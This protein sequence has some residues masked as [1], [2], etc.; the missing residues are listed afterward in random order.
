MLFLFLQGIILGLAAAISFGPAFFAVIQ[1]GI[2]RGFHYGAFMSVGIILSDIT[3]VTLCY[4]LGASL[5]EDPTNKVYI[6]I[7][8]GIILIIFG[9]VSWAKKPE[10]L[11][12]RHFN[13]Q[14]PIKTPNPPS[15]IIRGFFLNIANPFLFLFWFAALSFVGKNAPEGKLLESTIAFFSGTFTIILAFDLLKSYLGGRIKKILRPRV[16]LWINK[17]VGVLMVIF[18]IVLIFNTLNSVHFFKAVL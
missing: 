1:T 14:T 18:G 17:L 12:K 2:T 7:V 6:G 4:F 13:Y 15:F 8:G 3:W 10:I 11:K 5:F 16:E 9:S